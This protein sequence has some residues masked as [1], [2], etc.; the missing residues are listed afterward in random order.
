MLRTISRQSAL[1]AS[2][3]RWCSSG[4]MSG[5]S[6]YRFPGRRAVTRA[7]FCPPVGDRTGSGL[8]RLSLQGFVFRTIAEAGS[9]FRTIVEELRYETARQYL[10]TSLLEFSDV[11]LMLG[12]SEAS[13]F[14]RAFRRWSGVAPSAWRERLAATSPHPFP[15]GRA[16]ASRERG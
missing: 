13:A 1:A 11:A 8:G 10:A 3:R 4:V 7:D 16:T 5:T 6:T 9:S 2:P 14:S 12:Y 15:N